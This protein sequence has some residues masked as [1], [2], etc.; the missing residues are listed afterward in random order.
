MNHAIFDRTLFDP[1]FFSY[2]PSLSMELHVTLRT[3]DQWKFQET[4][5]QRI[6]LQAA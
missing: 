1:T 6:D 2:F 5:K 4:H 3:V